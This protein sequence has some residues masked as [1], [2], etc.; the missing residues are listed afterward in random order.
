MTLYG[1]GLRLNEVPALKVSD[2]DSNK[3][4]LFI[5]NAK[6]SKDRIYKDISNGALEG[7]NSR[8]KMKHRSGGGRAGKR[9]LRSIE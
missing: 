4:Q 9:G 3:M 8:I 6:G 5:R 2:I 1:E 7:M